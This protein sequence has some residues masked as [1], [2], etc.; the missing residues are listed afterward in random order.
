M[1][2]DGTQDKPFP[3]QPEQ[4]KQPIPVPPGISNFWCCHNGHLMGLILRQPVMVGKQ[5]RTL[6]RLILLRHAVKAGHPIPPDAGFATVDAASRVMCDICGD[7]Q[8]WV[9]G[10]QF[11]DMLKAR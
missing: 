6:P 3:E 8:D 5:K 11:I 4:P 10:Q 9:P 1:S 7:M 2:S